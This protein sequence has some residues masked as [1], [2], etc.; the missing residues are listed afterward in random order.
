MKGKELQP[1]NSINLSDINF[2]NEMMRDCFIAMSMKILNEFFMSTM[3]K[4]KI[5]YGSLAY[6]KQMGYN[7]EQIT[8]IKT[9][10]DE[11]IKRFHKPN[12]FMG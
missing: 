3:Q 1:N 8:T 6:L 9:G 2:P 5:F 11:L 4:Q 10:M 12:D 7:D